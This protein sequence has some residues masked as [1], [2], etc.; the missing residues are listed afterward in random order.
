MIESLSKYVFIK[1]IW[2]AVLWNAHSG[3]WRALTSYV[4]N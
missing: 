2:R 1:R 4:K 3:R